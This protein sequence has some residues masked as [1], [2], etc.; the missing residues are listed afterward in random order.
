[1]RPPAP[2]G[3]PPR[4]RGNPAIGRRHDAD[5]DGIACEPW[6]GESASG[7]KVHRYWRTGR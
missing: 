5:K 6:H 3:L 2:S 4:A 7:V 1:M